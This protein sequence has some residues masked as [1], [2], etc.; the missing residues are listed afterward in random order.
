MDVAVLCEV[1][2]GRHVCVGLGGLGG[3]VVGGGDVVV[4]AG[5]GEVVLG[6]GVGEQLV[7]R[8]E[9][10]V[11]V[12]E[13]EEG[14]QLA[15]ANVSKQVVGVVLDWVDR[16]VRVVLDRVNQVVGVVLD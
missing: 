3:T 15:G 13:C 4:G 2:K 14:E 10:A 16:V 7:D 5:A 11:L 6:A 8:L 12:D 9:L 1:D